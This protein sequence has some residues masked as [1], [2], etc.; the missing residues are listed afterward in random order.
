MH[1]TRMS[2]YM[3]DAVSIMREAMENGI[4]AEC[5]TDRDAFFKMN[6]IL[7]YHGQ[8]ISYRTYQRYKAAA[9]IYG[10]EEV[11]EQQKFDPMFRYLYQ[12][13]M[14]CQIEQKEN[15]YRAMREST[16]HEW[17]TYRWILERKFPEM[18]LRAVTQQLLAEQQLEQRMLELDLEG[19]G[20][21]TPAQT[22]KEKSQ[23]KPAVPMEK[24]TEQITFE[25]GAREEVMRHIPGDERAAFGEYWDY[26]QQQWDKKNPITSDYSFSDDTMKRMRWHYQVEFALWER[27]KK[28]WMKQVA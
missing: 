26:V 23:P 19:M 4:T 22:E 25:Q 3:S 10:E 18:N 16:G 5:L 9:L 20:I 21:I 1:P 11:E 28:K 2:K 7:E 14:R 13:I 6:E 8:H 15:L 17:H 24:P 12:T 27:D